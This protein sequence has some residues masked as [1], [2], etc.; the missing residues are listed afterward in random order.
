MLQSKFSA[1]QI[2]NVFLARKF[3]HYQCNSN[4]TIIKKRFRS[5]PTIDCKFFSSRRQPEN[6]TSPRTFNYHQNIN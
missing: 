1:Y 4:D 2:L 6:T 3:F 5:I